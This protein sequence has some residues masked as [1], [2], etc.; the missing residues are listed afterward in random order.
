MNTVKELKEQLE[1]LDENKPI[2]FRTTDGKN[3][4]FYAI[5]FGGVITDNSDNSYTVNQGIIFKSGK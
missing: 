2:E 4:D 3:L 5:N 1:K